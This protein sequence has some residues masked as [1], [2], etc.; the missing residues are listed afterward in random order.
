MKNFM[1]LIVAFGE[2]MCFLSGKPLKVTEVSVCTPHVGA[3]FYLD[4]LWG[5]N[6]HQQKKVL[7]T[8]VLATGNTECSSWSS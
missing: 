6:H 4:F 5:K 8:F 2:R 1:N 7:A 3:C